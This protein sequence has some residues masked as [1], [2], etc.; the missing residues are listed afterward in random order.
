MRLPMR[1]LLLLLVLVATTALTACGASRETDNPFT[2]P[3]GSS[4]SQPFGNG[5]EGSM[6]EAPKE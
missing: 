1:L 6:P 4:T 5:S 2:G 3:S